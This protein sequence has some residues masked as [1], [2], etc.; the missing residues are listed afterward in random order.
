MSLHPVDME[1]HLLS[2]VEQLMCL[3]R[4]PRAQQQRRDEP[5]ASSSST[6][7]SSNANKKEGPAEMSQDSRW[8][9]INDKYFP[10]HTLFLHIQ[11]RV[12]AKIKFSPK[13]K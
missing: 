6:D 1:S 13:T 3:S 7:S 10:V 8:E 11:I 9:V 2:E 12:V 5:L 4:M